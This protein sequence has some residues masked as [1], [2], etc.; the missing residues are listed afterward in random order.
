MYI[1]VIF[2]NSLHTG[3]PRITNNP[4]D[5]QLSIVRGDEEVTLTCIF[6]GGDINGSY[7]ER[8]SSGPLSH[9]NNISI[10]TSLSI[11]KIGSAN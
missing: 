6:T 4:S 8:V 9:S 11:D 5:V 3:V 10:L 1:Y 7:W 2:L